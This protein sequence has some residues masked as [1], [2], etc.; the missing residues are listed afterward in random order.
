[1]NAPNVTVINTHFH[2]DHARGNKYYPDA[3]VISG[4][5]IWRQWDFDTAYSKRPDVVLKPGE[6]RRIEMDDEVIDVIDFGSAHSPNDLVVFFNKR[7][8]LAAGDLVWTDMHPVLLD[9]NSDLVHWKMYLRRILDEIDFDSVVPGHG[10]ICEKDA[11]INFLDYFDSISG[12]LN[13]PEK[14]NRL[15]KKYNK[16]KTFPIFGNFGRTVKLL[17]HSAKMNTSK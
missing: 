17:K 12:S 10:E 15:K 11:V 3:L 7:K 13:D 4:E 1:V 6:R 14:L 8:V 2:L 16:Y 5:T 9:R